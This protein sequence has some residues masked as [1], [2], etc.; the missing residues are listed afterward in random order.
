MKSYIRKVFDDLSFFSMTFLN[1]YCGF[2]FEKFIIFLICYKF[3]KNE[4]FTFSLLLLFKML[5]LLV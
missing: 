4:L 5:F 1:S 3:E 2:D